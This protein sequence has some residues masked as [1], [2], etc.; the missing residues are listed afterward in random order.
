MKDV[1]T[2]IE[3][4]ERP[5][6]SAT[7]TK[8]PYVY[9]S[10]LLGAPLLALLILTVD[11]RANWWFLVITLFPTVSEVTIGVYIVK[12]T[13]STLQRRLSSCFF[14][15]R[16]GRG[17]YGLSAFFSFKCVIPVQQSVTRISM[18]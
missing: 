6:T 2:D 7:E 15:A 8:N 18:S 3:H 14:F 12:R 9:M 1:V 5:F 17:L 11:N 16:L 4:E 13:F 10:I